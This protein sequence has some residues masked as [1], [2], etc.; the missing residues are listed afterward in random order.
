MSS[1]SNFSE[2]LGSVSSSESTESVGVG[3][4]SSASEVQLV[5]ED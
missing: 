3:G 4:N 2:S 5:R 1:L